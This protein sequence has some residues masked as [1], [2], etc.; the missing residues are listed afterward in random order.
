MKIVFEISDRRAFKLSILLLA[1]V[2]L[3]SGALFLAVQQQYTLQC[4]GQRPGPPIQ[5]SQSSDLRTN[6]SA[7]RYEV[8]A[9]IFPD[10][11]RVNAG[12]SV[13]IWGAFFYRDG[14]RVT[15]LGWTCAGLELLDTQTGD[16]YW[17][18]LGW[19]PEQSMFY[20]D[21]TYDGVGMIMVTDVS[22]FVN[23]RDYA[24][25]IVQPAIIW[26]RI[27]FSEVKTV[28]TLPSFHGDTGVRLV[29]SWECDEGLELVEGECMP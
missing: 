2:I 21:L 28:I 13:R 8:Y 11:Q 4:F 20:L 22:I 19:S 3:Y 6:Q 15:P 14:L 23:N 17:T 29:G 10:D 1:G 16:A 12:E 25:D 7:Y 9:V 24:I 27:M 5:Q 26:D 18:A